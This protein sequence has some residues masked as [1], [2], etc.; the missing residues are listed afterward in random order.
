MD[1]RVGERGRM[2]F[3]LGTQLNDK[4]FILQ[5]HAVSYL[6]VALS[7]RIYTLKRTGG[8]GVDHHHHT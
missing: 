2:H 3:K 5:F 4:E 7:S 6:A 8:T 1:E